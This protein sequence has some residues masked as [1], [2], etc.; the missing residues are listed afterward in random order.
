MLVGSRASSKIYKRE[1]GMGIF[2]I[3]ASLYGTFVAHNLE[4]SVFIFFQGESRNKQNELK[5]NTLTLIRSL[6]LKLDL[7]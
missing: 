1:L 3:L 4:Y 6:L 7:S 2:N 5:P